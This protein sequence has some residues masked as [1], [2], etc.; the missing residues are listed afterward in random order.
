PYA[1]ECVDELDSIEEECKRMA[2]QQGSHNAEW[3]AYEIAATDLANRM[4]RDLLASK[5]IRVGT[6]GNTMEFE[7]IADALRDF[8][9]FLEDFAEAEGYGN[10]EYR[11][12]NL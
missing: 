2:D 5:F 7:L 11:V 8:K 12:I 9:A 1:Q 3:H 4:Y 10:V 6:Y